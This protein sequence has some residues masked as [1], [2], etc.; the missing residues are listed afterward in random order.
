MQIYMMMCIYTHA[1]RDRHDDDRRASECLLLL[2]LSQAVGF[3]LLCVHVFRRGDSHRG[4]QSDDDLSTCVCDVCAHD[5]VTP[6]VSLFFFFFSLSLCVCVRTCTHPQLT[7]THTHTQRTVN[8][9]K[10]P[11]PYSIFDSPRGGCVILS[12]GSIPTAIQKIKHIHHV[13]IGVIFLVKNDVSTNSSFFSKPISSSSF[14]L[15]SSLFCMRPLLLLSLP[16]LI[17]MCATTT[18]ACFCPKSQN[19]SNFS[20]PPF[21]SIN[22]L[23]FHMKRFTHFLSEVSMRFPLQYT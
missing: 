5:E 17:T 14:L 11:P 23:Q 20:F 9:R 1:H 6:A 3:Q 15:F 13:E 10:T 12:S 18:H 8:M 4:P 2:L 16:L 7:N 21:L 22:F 19:T